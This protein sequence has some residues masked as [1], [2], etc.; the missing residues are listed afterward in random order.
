MNLAPDVDIH[1]VVGP[2]SDSNIGFF[3]A[4]HCR[5]GMSGADLYS[6]V[7]RAAMLAIEEQVVLIQAGALVEEETRVVV[8]MQHLIDAA[9]EVRLDP[10]SRGKL[11]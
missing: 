5:D 8:N 1:F 2:P 4:K 10:F 11:L 7:S 9:G 3:Q 6:V